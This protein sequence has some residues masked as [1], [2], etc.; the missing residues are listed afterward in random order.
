[1]KTE[2]LSQMSSL[3]SI[4]KKLRNTKDSIITFCKISLYRL[5]RTDKTCILF[6]N[7]MGYGGA[8]LVLLEMAKVYKNLGYK[9]I[10][11]TH[12]YGKLMKIYKNNGIDVWISPLKGSVINKKIEIKIK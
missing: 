11:Y 9:V 12:Y 10:V 7:G 5:K 4:I 1:M 3:I 6:S 8:P 2:N